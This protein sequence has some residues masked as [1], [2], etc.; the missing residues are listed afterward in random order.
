MDEPLVRRTNQGA[1]FLG[2]V[3]LKWAIHKQIHF[4]HEAG[5]HLVALEGFTHITRETNDPQTRFPRSTRQCCTS[6]RLIE[7]LTPQE[8]QPLDACRESLG[9]NCFRAYHRTPARTE[10]MRIDAPFAT[11]ATPLHPHRGAQAWALN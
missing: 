3:A 4:C 5:S 9:N 7:W 6:N 10:Q 11:N 2:T 8:S 1:L